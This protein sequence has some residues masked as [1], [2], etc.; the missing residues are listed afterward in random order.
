MDK[1][2][3][4]LHNPASHGEVPS[5]EQVRLW[6]EQALE[7]WAMEN[8]DGAPALNPQLER[9]KEL[10]FGLG[11]AACLGFLLLVLMGS[12]GES[13]AGLYPEDWNLPS[14]ADITF[15]IRTHSTAVAAACLALAVLATKPLR[16]LLLEQLG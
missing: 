1:L 15:M 6:S 3:Q 2:E 7:R 4:L 9:F 5:S 11:L 12:L 13:F 10:V 16:E 8:Q 14:S